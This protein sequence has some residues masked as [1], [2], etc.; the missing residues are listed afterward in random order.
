ML[1]LES[2][3]AQTALK[4]GNENSKAFVEVIEKAE[5]GIEHFDIIDDVASIQSLLS[6]QS[7]PDPSDDKENRS[8]PT[9]NRRDS[10]SWIEKIGRYD[11]MLTEMEKLKAKHE[12]AQSDKVALREQI[13]KLHDEAENETQ[14]SHERLAGL[15]SEFKKVCSSPVYCRSGMIEF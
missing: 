7:L 8:T 9:G 15:L 12:R 2:V 13:Q 1:D 6:D 3:K 10:A 5:K 14:K 4:M 11:T